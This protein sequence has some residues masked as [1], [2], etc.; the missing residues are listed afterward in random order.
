M[1]HDCGQCKAMNKTEK[2]VSFCKNCEEPLCE[3]CDKQHRVIKA[4]RQHVLADI[5]I[6][7]QNYAYVL[8]RAVFVQNLMKIVWDTQ[9]EPAIFGVRRLHVDTYGGCWI[10]STITLIFLSKLKSYGSITVSVW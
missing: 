8:L 9:D 2:A 7:D 1:Y 3:A 5:A 4:T 6:L 10:Y